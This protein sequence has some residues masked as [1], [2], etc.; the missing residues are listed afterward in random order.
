LRSA[1]RRRAASLAFLRLNA[2]L[3]EPTHDQFGCINDAVIRLPAEQA[4]PHC[5]W[6]AR[7]TTGKLPV[8]LCAQGRALHISLLDRKTEG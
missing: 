3:A 7:M 2:A 1:C 6:R 5:L 4:M 8:S